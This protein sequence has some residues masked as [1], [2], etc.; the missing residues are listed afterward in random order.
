[1]AQHWPGRLQ[2]VPSMEGHALIG[3]KTFLSSMAAVE[4]SAAGTP[5]RD[6]SRL[7]PFWKYRTFSGGAA[8]TSATTQLRAQQRKQPSPMP[9]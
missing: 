6:T 4:V 1:M 2:I 8:L 9:T 7:E 5:G 3:P